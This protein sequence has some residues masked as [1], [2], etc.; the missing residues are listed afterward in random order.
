[1]EL[2][3]FLAATKI[4]FM[5]LLVQGLAAEAAEVRVIA[6]AAIS[7]VMAELGPQFERA[8]G[9]KLVI[10]YGIAGTIKRQIEAGEGFDLFLL[11]LATIGDLIKEGKIAAGAHKEIARVGFGMG[12]RAGAPKPDISSVEA[13]KGALLNAKSVTYPPK[14]RV[15]IHLASVFERLGISEQMKAK[16][17]PQPG[18]ERAAQAV[19]DGEAELGFAPT[20]ILLFVSGVELVGPFPPELQDYIVYTA[21]LF[22]DAREP[23]AARALIQFLTTPAAVAVIKAKGLEP[24]AP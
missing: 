5:I 17:K 8:T 22:T 13:F 16:T 23:E 4:G 3:S 15:G 2:R 12:A 18:P 20:N 10:Q 7:P 1:M 14:G 9:H 24:G 6:G 11:S 19:A 21:G